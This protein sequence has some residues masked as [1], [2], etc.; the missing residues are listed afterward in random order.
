M[1]T[2]V[3]T[4]LHGY[5]MLIVIII[6]YPGDYMCTNMKYNNMPKMAKV[7]VLIFFH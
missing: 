1:Y 3:Y 2:G 6:G 4:G 5:T 7:A